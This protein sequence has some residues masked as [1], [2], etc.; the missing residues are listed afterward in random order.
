MA[1]TLPQLQL[2]SRRRAV[3]LVRMLVALLL[4]TFITTAPV[5]AER[6][7]EPDP[8]AITAAFDELRTAIEDTHGLPQGP[9]TAFL[10]KVDAAEIALL[11]PA[12]QSAREAARNEQAAV[13]ILTALQ[14]QNQV[15]SDRLGYDGRTIDAQAEAIKRYVFANAW[16]S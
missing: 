16:P 12:V 4:F 10:A 3:T 1:L 2:R 14:Q 9:K 8:A 15:L 6:V 11:L 13:Q 7:E 5:S